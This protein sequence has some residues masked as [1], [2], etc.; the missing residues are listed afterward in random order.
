LAVVP[1]VDRLREAPGQR[2]SCSIPRQA[3]FSS[4]SKPRVV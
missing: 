4:V 1:L 3:L 2:S